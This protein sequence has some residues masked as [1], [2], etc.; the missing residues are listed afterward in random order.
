MIC[1]RCGA[2]T[3][4]GHERAQA[5]PRVDPIAKGRLVAIG[6]SLTPLATAMPAPR[7]Y[8]WGFALTAAVLC[9]ACL[10]F[11]SFSCSD[12]AACNAH[13][14]G[15]CAADGRCAYPD[16]ACPGGLRYDELADPDVAGEC[17]VGDT[18]SSSGVATSATTVT[19]LDTTADTGPQDSSGPATGDESS[20]GGGPSCGGAGEAC[21]ASGP[22]CGEGLECMGSAC[23]CVRQ[24]EAGDR[25]TCAVLVD[26]SVQCWGA[27]DV[28]QLGGS[29]APFE[30]TPIEALAVRPTDPIR[31][32]SATTHTCVRSE[33]GNVRCFG[34]NDSGQVD[35]ALP[36][37]I[38]PATPAAIVS[39][40]G[41]GTGASHTCA[42][43]GLSL[44]C[45]GANGQN[46]LTGG[47]A[48]PGPVSFGTG[49]V[50]QLETGG[51]FGCIV[52]G[53][54]LSCWGANDFGQLAT[55]PALTPTIATPTSMPIADVADV[56][57]GRSHTC[58]LTHAGAIGC[59]GRNNLGQLGDGSGVGQITPVAV[60]WP[61]EA[62]T[63]TAIASGDQHTCAID[64]AAALWCWG[65]NLGGQLMLEP[66]MGGNDMFTLTPVAIDVG[67]SVL[68]VSGGRDHTC[69]RTDAGEV[70]C[71]GT[72]TEGQ[73]GDGT[74]NYAFDPQAVM[75]G[76][77]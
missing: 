56:A 4:A 38:A 9:G 36:Q 51:A 30:T 66:D 77:P 3:P 28:G 76:C 39:A 5:G 35:P 52:Q 21:C 40:D 50:A 53:G 42:T 74:T 33:Q 14:G 70:L 20:S 17:V 13:D 10:R 45:W 1:K 63:P 24:I 8:A 60:A 37:P 31:Q 62:G 64:D 18:G 11:T 22:A 75:V 23:G 48:G 68:A 12:D 25:H 58:A 27:N 47:T 54:A 59:W 16:A 26:G 34:A 61:P 7:T 43:D 2:R 69:V 65:S 73:I 49:P 6:D 41:I 72:N 46:Q 55:D 44:S 57:L 29:A 19:T 32:I 67:A 15:V 71:W